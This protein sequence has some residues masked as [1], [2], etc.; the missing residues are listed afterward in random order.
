MKTIFSLVFLLVVG[1]CMAQHQLE[2]IW[3]TDTTLA[4]PESVLF[5]KGNIYVALID[6]AP[7]DMD[8]KGEIA[9]ISKDGKIENANWAKGLNAPKGMGVWNKNL[10]V[11]DVSSVA[12]T[13]SSSGKVES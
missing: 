2:K 8:G 3:E 13:D 1:T 6:G 10:Y 7:W 4:V 5:D 11:A 9:K 12:V